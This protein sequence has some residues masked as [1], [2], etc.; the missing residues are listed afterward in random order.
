M[1]NVKKVLFGAVA[2]VAGLL[3]GASNA[4]AGGTTL[5]GDQSTSINKTGADYSCVFNYNSTTC[6]L[7]L[8]V[9][10]TT[11]TA[12]GGYLTGLCFNVDKTG[13]TAVLASSSNGYYKDLCTSTQS[14]A[15]SNPFGTYHDGAGLGGTFGGTGNLNC[16][17]AAGK[18]DTYVF[19]VK[20]SNCPSLPTADFCDGGLACSFANI[21]LLSCYAS[22]KIQ[23]KPTCA[24]LPTSA[25]SG[26]LG[27][28]VLGATGLKH[29]RRIAK[30]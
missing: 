28:G 21:N 18:T 16:G 1:L 5:V 23:C 26:L 25:W 30:A 29:R 17:T 6:Q 11:P 15:L 13:D 3:A 22:D 12:E 27:L 7:T 19:N 14:N 9:T 8:Q 4:Y 24:P 2:T 20:G 10:N